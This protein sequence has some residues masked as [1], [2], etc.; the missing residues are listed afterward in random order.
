MKFRIVSD[1]HLEFIKDFDKK[2]KISSN[3][4]NYGSFVENFLKLPQVDGLIMAGDI[5]T[6]RQL[7][8][9][10]FEK[11]IK[12]I[13]GDY[14]HI[15]YILG[16]HEYYTNTDENVDVLPLY[17]EFCKK[18]DIIFLDNEFVE[19]EDDIKSI[20]IGGSTLWSPITENAALMM[21]D[22][23]FV[24]R[25]KV[26]KMNEKALEWI[27]KSVIPNNSENYD[28]SESE[29]HIDIMITHH[30][31]SHRFVA[32][33]YANYDNSGFANNSLDMYFKELPID[34]WIFGH[35]HTPMSKKM[36]GIQFVCNPFGYPEE[37]IGFK[38]S[39]NLDGYDKVIEIIK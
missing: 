33:R 1:I 24:S 6:F 10:S 27:K 11:F 39:G 18:H 8:D 13:R 35:T 3:S 21:N 20:K 32:E 15:I 25:K 19:I 22:M 9:G 28:V 7:N 31:P 5:V 16:N 34:Y 29:E 4:T 38:Y 12:L 23:R 30:L 26:L 14:K 36:H 37:N 17:R 2:S